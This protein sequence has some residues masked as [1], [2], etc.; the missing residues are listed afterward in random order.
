MR[1]TRYGQAVLD[2][3]PR[4]IPRYGSQEWEALPDHD[5]RILAAIVVAAECW[6]DYCSPE[7]VFEDLIQSQREDDAMVFARITETSDDVH[8]GLPFGFVDAPTHRE[9]VA[10]RAAPP[11]RGG[12][13]GN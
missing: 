13:D 7:T 9:L 4:P 1:P 12:T 8:A 5:P 6:R 10:R 11:R 3:A 2:A